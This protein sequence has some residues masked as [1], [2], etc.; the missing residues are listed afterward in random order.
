MDD[1]GIIAG[2]DPIAVDQASVDI[3]N[4]RFG[5]DFFRHIYP[6]VDYTIQLSYGEKIGLGARKYKIINL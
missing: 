3:V 4:E 1:I 5:S 2:N 6:E